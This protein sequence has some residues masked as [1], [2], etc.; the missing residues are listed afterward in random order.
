MP[1]QREYMKC[2]THRIP[3]KYR[4]IKRDRKVNCKMEILNFLINCG[5]VQLIFTR[6]D[7][8]E[9]TGR[10]FSSIAYLPVGDGKYNSTEITK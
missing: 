4:Y 3:I 9:Q 5:L 10:L 8:D 7:P 2:A 6:R 1:Y